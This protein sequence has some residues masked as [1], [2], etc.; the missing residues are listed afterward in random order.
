MVTV[1]NNIPRFKDGFD[2]T[3][4]QR[5]IIFHYPNQFRGTD[6]Q[7]KTLLKDILNTPQ[8]ME[9]LLFQ[10]ITAYKDMVINGRD[11]KARISEAKTMELLCKH[12][13]PIAY[14]LQKVIKYNENSEEDGEEP[15]IRDELNKL[16]VFIANK[17]GINLP[18]LKNNLIKP[19]TLINAVR[20]EF[21]LDK[22]YKIKP[23]ST[24][25]NPQ[26]QKY[27]Y[28]RGFP[29]FCK[30]PEY[31]EYLNEMEGNKKE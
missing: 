10:G 12:T 20:R 24:T 22:D 8:E 13:D 30:T 26:T 16:I 4:V 28:E 23:L 18:N 5:A 29:D 15:I 9:Y 2:D 7:N 31:D 17:E 19:Q 21:G 1:C 6:S 27:D 3:I 11:F 14:I 25:Y